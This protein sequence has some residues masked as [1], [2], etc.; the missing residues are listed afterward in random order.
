MA[1]MTYSSIF[2]YS[3]S[4]LD[5]SKA[6][7]R[8]LRIRSTGLGFQGLSFS[9]KT[10]DLL[11]SPHYEALS[12]ESGSEEP[13]HAIKI[14]PAKCT[15][16]IR[17]NLYEFLRELG[18]QRFK[19][20]DLW[21]A[22][23][24]I[25][26]SSV[27]ERNHHAELSKSI[28]SKATL[29][30]VWLGFPLDLPVPSACFEAG[31][32]TRR[33]RRHRHEHAAYVIQHLRAFSTSTYWSRIWTQPELRWNHS[34]VFCS[35][36]GADLY[37]GV[38]LDWDKTLE[39]RRAEDE[40]NIEPELT[41]RK[42]RRRAA[43]ILSYKSVSG[44]R[45]PLALSLRFWSKDPR[46]RVYGLMAEVCEGERLPVDYAESSEELWKRVANALRDRDPELSDQCIGVLNEL[47]AALGVFQRGFS[48]EYVVDLV[49]EA[50]ADVLPE[51]A[52]K[53]LLGSYAKLRIA[54]GI[55]HRVPQNVQ[56]QNEAY[57]FAPLSQTREEIR[58]FLVTD[59]DT[60]TQRLSGTLEIFNLEMAPQYLALSYEW[61]PPTSGK[62]SIYIDGR[63]LSL[64]SNL[65][66]FL[67]LAW[68]SG[69]FASQPIRYLWIDQVCI[70]QSSLQERG[71]QVQLMSRIF[72]QADAVIAWLGASREISWFFVS[73]NNYG[74]IPSPGNLEFRS[75]SFWTRLWIQQELILAKRLLFAAGKW[76]ATAESV[77]DLF[78]GD[79][80]ADLWVPVALTILLER[81]R[82]D[83][84][85][86][87]GSR[88]VSH[89]WDDEHRRPATRAQAEPRFIA[90]ARPQP[91]QREA[92]ATIIRQDNLLGKLDLLD[93]IQSFSDNDCSDPRDKVY[94]LLGMVKPT[95]RL[96]VDYSLPT[97]DVLFAALD[98][99][100]KH[101]SFADVAEH[102]VERVLCDL[103]G[104]MGLHIAVTGD[105]REYIERNFDTS[106]VKKQEWG[107]SELR[108]D[109]R[110]DGVVRTTYTM[111]PM[112]TSMPYRALYPI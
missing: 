106:L 60:T 79:E 100:L 76:C 75:S 39:S 27:E 93:A 69:T 3:L 89:P 15:L 103:A 96:T 7:T 24:C 43:D 83:T 110:D 88:P 50:R 44:I 95:Q 32:R 25:D 30:R 49:Q 61:G 77:L 107:A 13:E 20:K 8:L 16:L 29:V 42:Q 91:T 9:F 66:N 58:L 54:A 63:S 10:V 73:K 97:P 45:L 105:I 38:V 37:V 85:W 56:L 94:G 108:N 65:W 12:Y 111:T 101:S 26:L 80:A 40:D 87:T 48:R 4:P 17:A 47:G 82:Q 2:S 52:F 78:L 90:I 23:I 72:E 55:S 59:W 99:V 84:L 70:D 71:Q 18:Q 1:S 19:K 36:G 102:T 33:I 62:S 22:E 46:D 53:I 34:V 74:G 92:E 41:F 5:F 14:D 81:R 57:H 31:Q 109:E 104:A 67:H 98:L 68:V 112:F 35:L 51:L 64:R 21:V 6:Q 28:F 86:R 11:Q